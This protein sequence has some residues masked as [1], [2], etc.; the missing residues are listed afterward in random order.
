MV[1]IR[2]CV[3]EE[4]GKFTKEKSDRAVPL[5][6]QVNRLERILRDKGIAIYH[7]GVTDF[8]NT[9]ETEYG[10]YF[11]FQTK[12][13]RHFSCRNIFNIQDPEEF[14][15]EKFDRLIEETEITFNSK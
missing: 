15:T 6:K 12:S 11:S 1:N 10:V 2:I 13:G 3:D 4:A 8:M 14:L 5:Y 7:A 9:P